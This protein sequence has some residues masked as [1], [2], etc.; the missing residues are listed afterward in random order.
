MTE[1]ALE[2]WVGKYVSVSR[3]PQQGGAVPLTGRVQAVGNDGF[4]IQ[5]MEDP[6]QSGD[7]DPER[8]LPWNSVHAI[9][10]ASD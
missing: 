4:I 6:H 7:L 5:P 3:T 2:A 9:T 10:L 1:R 8:S